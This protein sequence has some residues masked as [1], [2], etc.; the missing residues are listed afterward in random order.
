VD[1]ARHKLANFGCQQV[2]DDF[3][4]AQGRSL[5]DNLD[6]LGMQ[7]TEYLALIAYRDGDDLPSGRCRSSGAAALTHPE[8]RVVYLCGDNSRAQRP[9]TRANTLIH[10]LL[11]SLGRGKIPRAPPRSTGRYENAVEL[12][13]PFGCK[14]EEGGQVMLFARKKE[15]TA[16]KLARAAGR[17]AGKAVRTGG[18]A[19]AAASVAGR[20]TGRTAGKVADAVSRTRKAVRRAAARR[21]VRK[22]LAEAGRSLKAVGKT[23]AVAGLAVAAAATVSEIVKRR[24]NS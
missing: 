17:V 22:T 6:A 19:A 1:S 23:A 7:P 10:E 16:T 24:R 11:H 12:E 4:D 3:R 8:D 13:G 5:R 20:A 18:K 15:T 2:L 21:K 9:G 14:M